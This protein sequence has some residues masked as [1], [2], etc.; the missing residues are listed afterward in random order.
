[1]VKRVLLVMCL[2]LIALFGLTNVS[3]AADNPPAK[4]YLFVIDKLSIDDINRA[5][6]PHLYDLAHQGAVG[7]QSNRTLGSGT[8]EDGALTIGA[9][10]LAQ[11]GYLHIL[12]YNVNSTVPGRNQ[13]AGQLYQ[14]LTGNQVGKSSVV[15]VNLPQLQQLLAEANVN[16]QLGALGEVLRKQGLK[17]SVIGNGDINGELSRMAAVIGMDAR[18]RVALGDVGTRTS[19]KA[20]DS[21]VTTQ[22]NY[23]FILRNLPNLSAGAQLIIIEL[24]NLARLEKADQAVPSMEAAERKKQLHEIDQFVS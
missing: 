3:Q 12:A 11:A 22:T 10:N 9:G 7:L 24:S 23:P 6:T 15:L 21:F 5:D 20:T 13:T 14:N 8:T 2:I 19:T 4:V 16:T 18:G 1:M 17:V